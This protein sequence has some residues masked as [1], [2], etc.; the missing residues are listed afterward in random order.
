MIHLN[1]HIICAIDVETT[2]L[3]PYEHEIV[4]ITFLPLDSNFKARKDVPIFDIRMKP[5][6]EEAIDWDAFKVT[7]IDFYKLMETGLDKYDAAELFIE[8]FEKLRLA[9]NKRIMPLAHNWQFDSGFIKAWLGPKNFHFHIDG[10]NRDTMCTALALN[11]RADRK[12]EPE[13]FPK[14]N[15]SY[16][17]NKL[18]VPHE[19]AHSALGD[20]VATAELYKELIIF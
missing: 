9:E 5:E 17:C 16:L 4:E 2:G 13:P 3:N 1:G 7:K 6:N 14:V 12:S 15:L 8:W 11:D 10:R 18:N 20:C 19:R